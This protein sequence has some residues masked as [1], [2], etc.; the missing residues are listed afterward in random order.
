MQTC[1]SAYTLEEPKL[2][3]ILIYS[4][5]FYSYTDNSSLRNGRKN[6]SFLF[7]KRKHEKKLPAVLSK[8]F[9]TIIVG[10]NKK[11]ILFAYAE[12]KVD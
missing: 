8:T 12:S 4:Y 9:K 11:M 6:G 3:K 7:L 5:L 1:L 10:V 2:L